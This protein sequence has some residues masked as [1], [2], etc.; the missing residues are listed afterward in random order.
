MRKSQKMSVNPQTIEKIKLVD[1]RLNPWNYKLVSRKGENYRTFLFS[2]KKY[3]EDDIYQAEGTVL[4][5]TK[6][7]LEKAG[8]IIENGEVFVKPCVTLFYVSGENDKIHFDTYD[9]AENFYMKLC[10]RLQLH[11]VF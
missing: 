6:T 9:E 4:E 10:D 5:M 11:Y 7:E 8:N 1:K 2:K 3:Y